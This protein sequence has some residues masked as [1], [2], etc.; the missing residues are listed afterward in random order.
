[1]WNETSGYTRPQRALWL[2]NTSGL[3]LD[4]GSFSV[5]EEETFAGE[6]IFDAIRPRRNAW[7]LTPPTLR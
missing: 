4:G 5:L 1:V 6:G 2:D 7:S 3:T